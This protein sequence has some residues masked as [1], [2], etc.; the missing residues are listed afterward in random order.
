MIDLTRCCGLFAAGWILLCLALS[1]VCLLSVVFLVSRWLTSLCVRPGVR[2]GE[3]RMDARGRS[4]HGQID[5][6]TDRQSEMRR[7]SCDWRTVP[8]SWLG[9]VEVAVC[10]VK[11][12]DF[13]ATSVHQTKT[14]AHVTACTFGTQTAAPRCETLI[15][16]AFAPRLVDLLMNA[17][18]PD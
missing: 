3:R 17:G 11:N 8:V 12:K 5:R 2:M 4:R 15:G 18:Q 13:A 6:Q 9:C 10:F 1:S 16:F 7:F 14:H